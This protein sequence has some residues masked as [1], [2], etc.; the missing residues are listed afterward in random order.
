ME[1]EREEEK[2]EGG[3]VDSCKCDLISIAPPPGSP[4]GLIGLKS[5]LSFR[6]SEKQLT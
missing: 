5:L 2:E 4:Y 3:G 6:G 1:K